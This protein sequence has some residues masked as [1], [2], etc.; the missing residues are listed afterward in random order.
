ML[1]VNHSQQPQSHKQAK[2][3]PKLDMILGVV[4]LA[5][6][7]AVYMAV[8]LLGEQN[9]VDVYSYDPTQT[10]AMRAARLSFSLLVV[11]ILAVAVKGGLLAIA[12]GYKLSGVIATF[13]VFYIAILVDILLYQHYSVFTVTTQCIGF[14]FWPVIAVLLAVIAEYLKRV[15]RIFPAVTAAVL[16]VCFSLSFV[17]ISASHTGC[18]MELFL[19]C[20]I[21][22]AVWLFAADGSS[23]KLKG[24]G[25]AALVIGVFGVLVCIAIQVRGWGSLDRCMQLLVY[26]LNYFLN[27]PAYGTAEEIAIYGNSLAMIAQFNVFAAVMY[28]TGCVLSGVFVLRACNK[29]AH[30]MN[31]SNR[32]IDA[33]ALRACG[34]AYAAEIVAV[35][36]ANLFD[37][38]CFFIDPGTR[39][40]LVQAGT[41]LI[42]VLIGARAFSSSTNPGAHETFTKT[43]E[44]V[45]TNALATLLKVKKACVVAFPCLFGDLAKPDNMVFSSFLATDADGNC[46]KCAGLF[47]FTACILKDTHCYLVF[48]DSE[49][50]EKGVV[51]VYVGRISKD[52]LED[53]GKYCNVIKLEEPSCEERVVAEKAF[54]PVQKELHCETDFLIYQK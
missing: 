31:E 52:T 27:F 12:K 11:F 15:F 2:C 45:Y 48:T 34:F 37:I 17:L 39:F 20:L 28:A 26:H 14:V 21:A 16:Y 13:A 53:N 44:R 41:I 22:A 54:G 6:A 33:L 30:C 38:K 42:A 23:K 49:L 51:N 24:A 19:A 5:C 25:V 32:K 4:C 10:L 3:S 46:V 7:I 8:F 40:G 18:K 35:L 50:E 29:L 43:E 47:T 9:T 36:V 1:Q